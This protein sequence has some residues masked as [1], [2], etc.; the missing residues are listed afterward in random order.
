MRSAWLSLCLLLTGPSCALLAGLDDYGPGLAGG[1]GPGGE[2][3]GGETQGGGGQGAGSVGGAGGAG[4]MPTMDC[5][6]AAS[7]PRAFHAA[8]SAV[9]LEAMAI[10]DD[11]SAL[12][13]LTGASIIQP[14]DG[15]IVGGGATNNTRRVVVIEPDGEIGSVRKLDSE[16]APAALTVGG[17]TRD[18]Q[19]RWVIVGSFSGSLSYDDQKI[20]RSA[21]GED[22]FW[23]RLES[24][25]ELLDVQPVTGP[26]SDRVRDVARGE[27][28][29]IAIVGDGAIE[30]SLGEAFIVYPGSNRSGFAF[31]LDG[32]LNAPRGHAMDDGIDTAATMWTAAW[33]GGSLVLAATF[34]NPSTNGTIDFSGQSYPSNRVDGY[35]ARLQ[36][37]SPFDEQGLVHLT[38]PEAQAI[39][40]VAPG[41]QPDQLYIVYQWQ[42]GTAYDLFGVVGPTAVAP[43]DHRVGVALVDMVAQQVIWKR[44]LGGAGLTNVAAS[45][46]P[47]RE[48]AVMDDGTLMVATMAWGSVDADATGGAEVLV[49]GTGSA[50]LLGYQPDGSN[51]LAYLLE[52]TTGLERFVSIEAE[53]DRLLIAAVYTNQLTWG[54]RLPAAATAAVV[55]G[56]RRLRELSD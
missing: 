6:E 16:D 34:G 30:T 33:H 50:L 5:D 37:G 17:A 21:L 27:D 32:E 22:G 51:T 41:P 20:I 8:S 15:Q 42:S 40:A 46:A 25:G 2:G 52:D 1:A 56:S 35:A 24:N 14:I 4:G 28:G 43:P 26:G 49:D 13:V 11:C 29:S 3:Q 55:V 12:V 23:L 53:E 44:D 18:A 10:G 31:T 47:M 54:R 45:S 36:P 39:R 48:L 7:W 38:G 19:N 9:T